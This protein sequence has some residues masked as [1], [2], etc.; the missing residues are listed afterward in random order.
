MTSGQTNPVMIPTL[1]FR[2]GDLSA[3]P[4]IIYNPTTGAANGTGRS[5]W[6]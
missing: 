6:E 1:A 4:T 2:K 5:F 3:S